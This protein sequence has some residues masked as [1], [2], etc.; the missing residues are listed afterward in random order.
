M[1]TPTV[2]PTA[3]EEFLRAGTT[4][5][6]KYYLNPYAGTGV[7]NG[8]AS[9]LTTAQLNG[10]LIAIMSDSAF[11]TLLTAVPGRSVLDA[12]IALSTTSFEGASTLAN[13]IAIDPFGTTY[14]TNTAAL[15][16]Q[17]FLTA[18]ALAQSGPVNVRGGTPQQALELAELGTL[19]SINRFKEVWQ[20]T[21]AMAQLVNEASRVYSAIETSRRADQMK[22]AELEAGIVQGYS[23]RIIEGAGVVTQEHSAQTRVAAAYAEL[24]GQPVFETDEQVGGVGQQGPVTTGFGM[25]VWR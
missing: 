9:G 7:L 5:Q 16:D 11:T 2:T 19:Q 13:I 8:I 18:R 12:I 3:G 20:N 23:G 1:P 22:A 6:K 25:S 21:L 4:L 24:F 10:S 15:Y 14:Q 17:L